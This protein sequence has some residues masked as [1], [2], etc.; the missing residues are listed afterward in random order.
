MSE[1]ELNTLVEELRVPV[2]LLVFDDPWLDMLY[3]PL[4]E[5]PAWSPA[6]VALVAEF[7]ARTGGVR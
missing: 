5:L 1:L 4:P 2:A 3:G 7:E 6:T